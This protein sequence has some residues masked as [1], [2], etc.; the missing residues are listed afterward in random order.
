MLFNPET[1]DLLCSGS[2]REIFRFNL[3]EGRFLASLQASPGSGGGDKG[4]EAIGLSPV[5]GLFA[6]AGSDGLLECHDL[7]AKSRCVFTTLHCLHYTAVA[8]ARFFLLHS[9]PSR[10]I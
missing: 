6:S 2:T 3:H 10:H 5:H 1:C 4:I 7:R 9:F 8:F